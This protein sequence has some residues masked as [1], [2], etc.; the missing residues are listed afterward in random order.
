MLMHRPSGSQAGWIR[1][2]GAAVVSCPGAALPMGI[3]HRARLVEGGDLS[4][5]FRGALKPLVIERTVQLV[6]PGFCGAQGVRAV[7]GDCFS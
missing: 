2:I 6:Q 1:F 7:A 5:G 3:Q 4:G